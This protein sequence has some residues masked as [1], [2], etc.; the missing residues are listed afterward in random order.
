MSENNEI[1]MSVS[2]AKA[3]IARLAEMPFEDM[4]T[5]HSEALTSFDP[6]LGPYAEKL[7]RENPDITYAEVAEIYDADQLLNARMEKPTRE[8]VL[9]LLAHQTEI[10]KQRMI[11]A[12]EAYVVTEDNGAKVAYLA[13]GER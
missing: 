5:A 9:E 2:M 7:V 1:L 10:E 12:G 11:A 8:A 6:V 4:M 13:A 3:V